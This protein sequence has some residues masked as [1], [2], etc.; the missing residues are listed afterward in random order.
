MFHQRSVQDKCRHTTLLGALI[1]GSF[2]S[3]PM[4]K[5]CLLGVLKQTYLTKVRFQRFFVLVGFKI[6]DTQN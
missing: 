2:R 6:P 4:E 5:T 3:F 1:P